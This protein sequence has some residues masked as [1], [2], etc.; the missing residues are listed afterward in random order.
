M[1]W[2]FFVVVALLD[3]VTSH[4]C[5]ILLERLF[6]VF[7]V[8]RGRDDFVTVFITRFVDDTGII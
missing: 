7:F 5:R 6:V 2:V 8:S 1:Q 3:V 4:R